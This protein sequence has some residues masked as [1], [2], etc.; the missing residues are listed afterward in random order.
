M[1]VRHGKNRWAADVVVGGPGA[2]FV[3]PSRVPQDLVCYHTVCV[4]GG[5]G[6]W[7]C[8][9]AVQDRAAFVIPLSEQG[10]VCYP[11]AGAGLGLLSR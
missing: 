1:R 2:R 4:C 6:G 9:P 11:T 3:I 10:W 8:Y 7:V 5:G